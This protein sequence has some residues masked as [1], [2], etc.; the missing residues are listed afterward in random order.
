MASAKKQ[1]STTTAMEVGASVLAAAAAAGAT[2][3]FYGDKSA[4]RHRASATKWAKG[5]K[6]DVLKQAKKVQKL[7]QKTMAA[8]V[9]KA[10]AAYSTVKSVNKEDLT[11][12]TRELKKHWKSVQAEL[13]TMKSKAGGVKK[14]ASKTGSTA[15][16]A[17]KKS[18]GTVKKASTKRAR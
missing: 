15:K 18:A 2:Y 8:I 6:E 3:Y 16:K 11:A 13:D 14:A 7:D 9:D 12:A 4:K 1:S 17:V 10:A 5:M